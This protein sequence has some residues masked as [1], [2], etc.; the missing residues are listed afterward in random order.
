MDSSSI[1]R[2]LR[3]LLP[4]LLVMGLVACSSQPTPAPTPALTPAATA[5]AAATAGPTPTATVLPPVE[6]ELLT[7]PAAF[8]YEMTL[9]PAGAAEAPYTVVMGQ[10][11]GGMWSQSARHGEDTPEE[12]IVALAADGGDA[13]HSYT[14]AATDVVWTRWPGVGFD[15]AHGLTSP[16]A[17][18]R[19][20]PLAD[21][22][23]RGELDPVQGVPEATVK[24]QAAFAPATIARLM[25]ASASVV[26]T[27]A[28]SRAALETQL[29]PVMVAQT[30]NYWVAESGRVY[31][32]A[33]TLL[34][35]G[36]NSEP[37]PWLEVT[38]RFWD[39]DASGLVVS[40]PGDFTDVSELAVAP[41]A[42]QV[43]AVLDAATTL[44]VRVFGNPGELA[45]NARVT[46]YPAGERQVLDQLSA[47][48]AQ[49]VL[50]NGKYDVLVQAEKAEEWLKEVEVISGTVASQ[51][52]LFAFGALEITVTQD[53]ATPQV[54]IVI[55]PA[56]Q[57]QTMADW[58]TE[59]PTRAVL[60]AGTY[61]IEVALPDYT[62]SKIVT[63]VVVTAGGTTQQVI[64]ISANP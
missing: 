25:R 3:G 60:P 30:I 18:L 15:A 41:V 5:E 47:A 31:R 36:E 14:R 35:A 54:D 42:A 53:G 56:G 21:E 7:L 13:M 62:G 22:Q 9:R 29:Q 58:R 46:V 27:D 38:W 40:A 55:Y 11:S 6:P 44:R 51:D 26:T 4:L 34:T 61:D 43:E 49:F 57:R 10:Y 64:D 19:L 37:A 39:Y 12:L 28:E 17:V 24:M 23:A 48:D 20:Y 45:S 52:V 50:P 1:L 33:A 2:V 32:A 59:N 63:D 8:R 16:F